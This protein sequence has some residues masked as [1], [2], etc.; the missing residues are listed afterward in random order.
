MCWGKHQTEKIHVLE[1]KHS[2]GIFSSYVILR[3]K[4]SSHKQTKPP[5]VLYFECPTIGQQYRLRHLFPVRILEMKPYSQN[6]E[7]H[8]Q[9]IYLL[10]IQLSANLAQ[11]RNLNKGIDQISVLNSPVFLEAPQYIEFL[12]SDGN[13]PAILNLKRH[14]YRGHPS[15][16]AMRQS[17]YL[18]TNMPSTVP[19]AINSCLK[20]VPIPY[21]SPAFNIALTIWNIVSDM[22]GNKAQ[23]VVLA[24]TAAA[25]L[26]TLN[27]QYRGHK[28]LDRNTKQ[29][30]N[31]MLQ[32]VL[33][34]S[35]YQVQ[36]KL[37]RRK[38]ASFNRRLC[39]KGKISWIPQ[40]SY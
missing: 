24:E 31:E 28:E 20:L 38:T 11:T 2:D 25:L 40:G 10:A 14:L 16:Q 8:T 3:I 36:S 1:K 26:V 17:P 37:N 39:A 22:Q 6:F 33:T 29:T 12:T 4:Q 19:D 13:M 32:Y 23:F 7:Q 15:S 9:L 18:P 21:L 5:R 30:L 34:T 35:L 27:K